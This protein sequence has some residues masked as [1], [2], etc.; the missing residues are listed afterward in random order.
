VDSTHADASNAHDGTDPNHPKATLA[1]AIAAA[2]ANHADWIIVGSNHAENVATAGAIT[3]NR[4][5]V[6]ILGV[7]TG[8]DR[9][10]FTFTNAAGSIIVSSPNVTIEN[11]LFV[12][13]ADSIA[14]MVDINADDVAVVGCEFRENTAV[15][16]QFLTAIDI[17]GGGANAADRAKVV[18]CK[19]VS[20][21]AGA[22]QAIEIGAVEDGVEIIGNF[23]TGDYS[24]AGIHSGSILT[25]ALI[26]NNYIRNINAGDFAI[27]LS[28]A[29]TGML[30]DNR[31]YADAPATILDPGSLICLGNLAVD[32]IDQAGVPIPQAGMVGQDY[33]I[34]RAT[35]ALP[36][37]AAAN[38]FTVSGGNVLLKQIIGTVTVNIGAVAN[39]TQL[40]FGATALCADLDINGLLATS[41]FSITGTFA[42][43]MINT[44]AT[45]P[46]AKQ[47]TEL[48]LPPGNL[49]IDCNGSDGGGGRVQW[50][51]IYQP[52]N[53]GAVIT[54]A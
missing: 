23:I 42:N 21:A 4:A 31:L 15:A 9:P 20:E 47:A 52:L 18:G 28:A 5:G 35:S 44:L 54:V 3:V 24:V 38:L 29:A 13:G 41:R 46:L 36:Q 11:L 49:S 6:H 50:T 17:N 19:F 1:S 30:I 10:T 51:V 40:L 25:N 48:V 53:E 45:V 2:T 7:G 43:A 32:A 14:I 37:T 34:D 27:E 33:I 22:T 39:A 8:M 16:Q 26:A 12:C